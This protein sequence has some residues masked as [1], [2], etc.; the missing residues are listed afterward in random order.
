LTR[1]SVCVDASVL[2][3]FLTPGPLSE[4]AVAAISTWLGEERIL[5]APTLCAYEVAS[6]LRRLVYLRQLTPDDGD[7][8]FSIF[9]AL[10][11]RYIHRPEILTRLCPFS[12]HALNPTTVDGGP[13][14]E[15][16]EPWV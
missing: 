10:D 12:G 16:D 1:S 2:L 13:R 7:A 5:V 6:V 15:I 8:A 3:R 4:V 9:R 14:S 11:V